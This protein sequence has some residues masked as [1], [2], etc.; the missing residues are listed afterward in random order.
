MKLGWC[1]W[2]WIP[3]L[4]KFLESILTKILGIWSR[5]SRNKETSHSSF[6]TM[7]QNHQ[8]RKCQIFRLLGNDTWISSTFYSSE[9][10]FWT[11]KIRF[12]SHIKKFWKQQ[13]QTIKHNCLEFRL[14]LCLRTWHP[15]RESYLP[16]ILLFNNKSLFYFLLVT[17]LWCTWPRK[18]PQGWSAWNLSTLFIKTWQQGELWVL[19]SKYWSWLTL[20][21]LTL[22]YYWWVEIWP[23][24]EQDGIKMVKHPNNSQ[25]SKL[26]FLY[27][28]L[29]SSTQILNN[30][31]IRFNIILNRWIFKMTFE[32][33]TFA[34]CSNWTKLIREPCPSARTLIVGILK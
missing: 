8:H 4:P 18:L 14:S 22:S 25:T 13:L 31:S 19:L 9:H 5:S 29:K 11:P 26:L 33:F 3:T 24:L 6:K 23:N 7:S 34:Q 32:Y 16:T 28:D 20:H 2:Q 15:T 10:L 12:S 30:A 1:L 17:V 21:L 27:I